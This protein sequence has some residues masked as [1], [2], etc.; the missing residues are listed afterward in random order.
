[1]KHISK[2]QHVLALV[3]PFV[4]FGYFSNLILYIYTTYCKFTVALF[5]NFT[6]YLLYILCF[7]HV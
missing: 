1:M 2:D 6:I 7:Y 5:D 4:S 3:L